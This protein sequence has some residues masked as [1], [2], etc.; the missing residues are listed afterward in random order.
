MVGLVA[1]MIREQPPFFLPSLIAGLAWSV[2]TWMKTTYTVQYNT[3]YIHYAYTVQYN[4]LH[5][6]VDNV[7]IVHMRQ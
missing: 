5:I 3:L 2:G 4:I 6:A 7:D 1:N